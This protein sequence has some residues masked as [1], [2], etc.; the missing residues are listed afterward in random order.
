[1]WTEAK[2]HEYWNHFITRWALEK[3]GGGYGPTGTKVTAAKLRKA[4]SVI[5][6]DTSFWG[7]ILLRHGGVEITPE[8][9]MKGPPEIYNH[10]ASNFWGMLNCIM[11]EHHIL[12]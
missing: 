8:Q 3:L 7:D 10:C 11:A 4:K 5:W 6:E 2:K 1:M 9:M 12:L